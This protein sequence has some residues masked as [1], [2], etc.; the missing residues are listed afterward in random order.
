MPH[1]DT[2][3]WKS[4]PIAIIGLSCKFAGDAT[5][6]ENLW[7]MLA[8]GRNAWSEI[9]ATRFNAKGVYHPDP[10]RL[11]TVSPSL[12]RRLISRGA[13]RTT[14]ELTSKGQ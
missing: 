10:D 4:E 7:R 8:E 3:E 5:S 14:K 6:P 2:N 1:C 11:G 12:L 9:P 13:Y